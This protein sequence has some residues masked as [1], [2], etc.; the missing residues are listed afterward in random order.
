MVTLPALPTVNC[1]FA[2]QWPSCDFLCSI[3]DLK[4]SDLYDRPRNPVSVSAPPCHLAYEHDRK[5]RRI[6]NE[7]DWQGRDKGSKLQSE[8]QLAEEEHLEPGLRVDIGSLPLGFDDQDVEDWI[9]HNVCVD[10]EENFQP[11]MQDTDHE[12]R[13]LSSHLLDTDREES[14][15]SDTKEVEK[16]PN[17]ESETQGEGSAS[18]G[19]LLCCPYCE[20]P[21]DDLMIACENHNPELWFHFRRVELFQPPGEKETWECPDCVALKPRQW[22]NQKDAHRDHPSGHKDKSPEHP[23]PIPRK[24]KKE[25]WTKPEEN[26]VIMLMREIKDEG[27][28]FHTEQK[29]IDISNRLLKL[30]SINR[31]PASVKNHWSRKLRAISGMDERIVQNPAKLTTSRMT[32]EQRK[33]S[34]KKRKAKDAAAD[35]NNASG[36]SLTKRCRKS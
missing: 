2:A 7:A 30:Y 8:A 20:E 11:K 12:E 18:P 23:S 35:D 29:W 36:L 25:A 16:S 1:P 26:L 15:E 5:T 34:R 10:L 9:W 4:Q 28:N 21:D 3:C 19:Y 17:L 31:S 27:I 24:I 14:F 6:L 22:D 33:A 32:S 13:S